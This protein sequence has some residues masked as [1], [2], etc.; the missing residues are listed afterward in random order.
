VESAKLA[1]SLR[2]FSAIRAHLGEL[3]G[4]VRGRARERDRLGLALVAAMVACAVFSLSVVTCGS[5]A[6]VAMGRHHLQPSFVPWA[7]IQLVPAG[8]AFDSHVVM[9]PVKRPDQFFR[10]E[11]HVMKVV[12]EERFR[13][14]L[15]AIGCVFYGIV[16]SYRGESVASMFDVCP[17]GIDEERIVRRRRAIA[18][19]PA[20]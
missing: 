5:A 15:P 9:G 16:T 19:P 1:F 6:R 2:F 4:F 8:M 14:M 12:Y 20:E 3:V 17:T 11:S 13:R 7:T 18:R 10:V